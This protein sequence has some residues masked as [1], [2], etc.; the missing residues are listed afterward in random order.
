VCYPQIAIV[1]FDSF[2][3]FWKR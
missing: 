1:T 2:T 3:K